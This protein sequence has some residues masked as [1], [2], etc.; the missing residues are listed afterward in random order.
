MSE[1]QVLPVLP[2]PPAHY[3]GLPILGAT[4]EFVSGDTLN[5]VGRIAKE[6]DVVRFRAGL[7]TCFLVTGPEA[8]S[9]VL[10]THAKSYGKDTRSYRMLAHTLGQGLVT[11][12]G[13]LWKKQRRTIQPLFHRQRIAGFGTAMV[14]A[15]SELLAEWRKGSEPTLDVHREMMKLALW[16]VCRTILSMEVSQSVDEIGHALDVV[17]SRTNQLALNPASFPLWVP[18]PANREL[19]KAIALLN[20][21][22]MGAIRARRAAGP[23]PKGDLLDLLMAAK[24][25][26]T[27]EGMDDQ[28]LRDEVMTLF[29]AGHE[30]TANGLTWTLYLLSEH[31]EIAAKLRAELESVLGGRAPTLEDIPKLELLDRVIKESLRLYPPVWGVERGATGEDLLGGHRVRKGDAV[32]VCAY[33]THRRADLWTEAESFRPDRWLPTGDGAKNKGAYLPFITGNRKCIGD[34]F[35]L[36]EMRLVLAKLLQEV[37]L[38]LSEGETVVPEPTVTLRP[39]DGMRMDV[40]WTGLRRTA[41][42]G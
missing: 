18:T 10:L 9:Q 39:R 29:T 37:Q 41:M 7:Q 6:G 11:S 30:T 8:I 27:G 21:V 42:H 2:P 32:I 33:I 20:E 36:T 5:V 3:R 22:V 14:E 19:R 1:A 16:V 26:E 24:D 35:A 40:Q 13:E 15:T 31:P 34:V 28:Q 25:E 4:L 38:T 23:S 17:V 12:D